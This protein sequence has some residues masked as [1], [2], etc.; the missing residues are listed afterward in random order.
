MKVFIAAIAVL[1]IAVGIFIIASVLPPALNILN[2]SSDSQLLQGFF[3]WLMSDTNALRDKAPEELLEVFQTF[4]KVIVVVVFL[5]ACVKL[6]RV[7]LLVIRE[8]VHLLRP[9]TDGKTKAEK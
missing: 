8:G 7:G 6:V 4:T 2:V 5:Y 9:S 3:D 1:L